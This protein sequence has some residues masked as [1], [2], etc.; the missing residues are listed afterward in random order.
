MKEN[1]KARHR[2]LRKSNVGRGCE[3]LASIKWRSGSREPCAASPRRSP[4]CGGFPFPSA[5]HVGQLIN[6]AT[7]TPSG[8]MTAPYC[9]AFVDRDGRVFDALEF[10]SSRDEAAIEEARRLDV[11]SIGAGFD[12]RHKDRL[13]YRHRR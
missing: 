8:K 10:E 3:R 13:V 11:P 5:E 4:S 12:L 6:A 9:L 7:V 1:C 2:I